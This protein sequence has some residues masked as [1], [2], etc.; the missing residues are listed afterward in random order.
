MTSAEAARPVQNPDVLDYVLRGRAAFYRST[1]PESNAEARNSFEH[2]LE[3]DPQSTDAQLGLAQVLVQRVMDFDSKTAADDIKR[4]GMLADRALAAAPRSSIAHATK[5]GVLRAQRRCTEAIPE[6]ETALALNHNEVGA[7]ASIGRCK[8]FVGPIEEAIPLLQQAIR[9]SPR[10]PFIVY[11]YYRIGE[12]YLLQSRNDEAIEWLEKARSANP[13]L[14]FVHACLASAYALKD[15][16][17][18]A[19]VEL[20]EARRLWGG[21]QRWSVALF[22]AGTRYETPAIRALADATYYKGL[23]KAGMPE[24]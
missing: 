4:A 9:L 13:G 11:W 16:T 1:S 21:S 24:K 19:E 15:E 2:A 23:R 8:I 7:L 5:A 18:R 10:D 14:W 6:Y 17:S 22:R 12:A 20:A 3:L